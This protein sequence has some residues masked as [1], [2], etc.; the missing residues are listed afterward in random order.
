[1][2]P[3]V[4]VCLCYIGALVGAGFASGKELELFFSRF[5]G[6]SLVSTLFAGALFAFLGYATLRLCQWRQISSPKDF[7]SFCLGKTL[8]GLT[9][10][11][12]ELFL[13]FSVTVMIA[14]SD[15]LFQVFFQGTP[16][17]GGA[18]LALLLFFSLHYPKNAM[19]LANLVLVPLLLIMMTGLWQNAI[20]FTTLHAAQT[21]IMAAAPGAYRAP[22][23]WALLYVSYNFLSTSTVIIPF[24]N[25]KGNENSRK[26]LAAAGGFWGG[27]TLGVLLWLGTLALLSQAG[28]TDHSPMPFLTMAA[29]QKKGAPAYAFPLWAA[30]F[31]TAIANSFSI[32]QTAS[33]P[34]KV[35]LLTLAF[36]IAYH[37]DFSG[38]VS[39][40]YP[41]TGLGGFL[42][43][44]A[45]CYHFIRLILLKR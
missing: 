27:I 6:L 11:F 44:F 9:F 15:S 10:R 5:S 42:F 7:F 34:R 17:V 45:I 18:I 38:L 22:F 19:V 29:A 43:L 24:A 40:L 39:L 3:A 21:E 41:L 1:M 31:T 35:I 30:I 28:L 14:A 33:L 2:S 13:F 32:L 12:L 36:F 4:Q 37:W 25:Q 20:S 8:G 23:F 26:T 16:G